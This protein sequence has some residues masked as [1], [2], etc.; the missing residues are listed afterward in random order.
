MTDASWTIG[1]AHPVRRSVG[2][3]SRLARHDEQL[4]AAP[5]LLARD[6]ALDRVARAERHGHELADPPVADIDAV[7]PRLIGQ[8]D[9]V[10][11][12]T[13]ASRLK[14]VGPGVPGHRVHLADA[15]LHRGA[16][17]PIGQREADP[18][19]L[20]LVHRDEDAAAAAPLV[21]NAI[22]ESAHRQHRER[23][24]AGRQR[25]L[26]TVVRDAQR[27]LELD[28]DVAELKLVV[29]KA[30]LDRRCGASVVMV[31]SF[32]SSARWTCILTVDTGD[33]QDAAMTDESFR[34]QDLADAAGV[35]PRTVRYYIAQG[36]LPSPGRLGANTRYGREH[37]ER[38]RLIRRL[39]DQGLP[40]AEIRDRV[41]DQPALMSA[42]MLAEASPPPGHADVPP[43][44]P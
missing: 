11:L 9:V 12:P 5:R 3:G 13:V 1:P 18:E 15:D 17:L 32:W 41:D 8:D 33:C 26:A 22:G 30:R 42:P 36:L 10:L 28:A 6:L 43:G 19:R 25:V 16:R 40:L 21:G 7:E 27:A 39:Q 31:V 37:L 20:A 4:D 24:E 2:R 34:L 44:L 35:T 29:A 23:A 38:L 14:P